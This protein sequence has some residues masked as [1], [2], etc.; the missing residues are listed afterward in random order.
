MNFELF[1]VCMA[2]GTFKLFEGRCITQIAPISSQQAV[3]NA[4][5]ASVSFQQVEA[6]R[7]S[8]L[9]DSL[10]KIASVAAPFLNFIPGIG[11]IAS[12]IAGT[13]GSIL[14]PSKPVAH[15]N[16][17]AAVATPQANVPV[18][19]NMGRNVG[20]RM[21]RGGSARGYGGSKC[22]S[23]GKGVRGYG[24]KLIS[25]SQLQRII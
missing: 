19:A 3:M 20:G 13:V 17:V 14:N 5:E 1:V 7:G 15:T 6:M 21:I 8:G 23:K 10:G 22:T 25:G 12:S 2:E 16:P 24:G 18:A 11:P 9:F 4:P